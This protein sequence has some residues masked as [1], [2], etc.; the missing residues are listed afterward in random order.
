MI[1]DLEIANHTVPQCA[2]KVRR[3]RELGPYSP[4]NDPN[5]CGCYFDAHIPGG[6]APASCKT[7]TTTPECGDAGNMICSYGY[8]EAK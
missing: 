1:I 2:M 6:T 3:T 5:P 7:C 4:S 8:C